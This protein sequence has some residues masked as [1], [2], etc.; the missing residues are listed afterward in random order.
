MESMKTNPSAR[1]LAKS[2]AITL[3]MLIGAIAGIEIGLGEGLASRIGRTTT[4][5]NEGAETLNVGL[6][7]LMAAV[8]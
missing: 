3:L 4:I 2:R 1:G 6:S 8:P 7:E 5:R